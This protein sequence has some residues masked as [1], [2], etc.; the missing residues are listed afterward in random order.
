MV[1]ISGKREAAGDLNQVGIDEEVSFMA[2]P[3]SSRSEAYVDLV[4]SSS[5]HIY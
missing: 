5:M 1:A 4:L 3:G 2:H